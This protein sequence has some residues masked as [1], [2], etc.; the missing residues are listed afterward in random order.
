MNDLIF[1][2]L[3]FG[4]VGFSGVFVDFGTTW[5]LKDKLGVNK[6][7]A[8]SI[9]FMLAVVSNYILNRIWTFQDTNPDI[10][11]QFGK[12]LLIALVGLA[13]NNG[14]IY[15]LTERKMKVNFYVAKILATGVVTFWNFGANVL[16][17][18]A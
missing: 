9:G 12:F 16:F 11:I 14:I 10:A 1:K 7:T 2:F 6:Y 5:L 3:K 17:T 13:I 8:N 15:L 4:V 18:F